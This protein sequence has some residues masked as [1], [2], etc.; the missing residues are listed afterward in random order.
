M[1]RKIMGKLLCIILIAATMTG[2]F[3]N[4]VYAKTDYGKYSNTK[5][6][7]YIMRQEKHKP[8]GGADTAKN[9]LKYN[10][11]YYDGKTE[12]KVMYLA[13]DCGYENGYT[14][15]ILDTLKE[16]NV[17]AMF[18]VTKGFVESNPKLCKRMKKE[19]HMVGN[20]TLNHPSL[21]S[22][23]VKGIK[24]EVKGLAKLFKEKT[25]YELDKYIRPP[26]GEYSNRVLKVLQ[27]MGYTTIFWSIAYYDYD[28]AKQPGKDYVVEHFKK[29]YHKGAITLTHN[30]SK[31][32]TEALGDVLTFL[33][34]K[35]YRFGTLNELNR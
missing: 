31:S 13:F 12:E 34:G 20:H 8:S 27:K 6:S 2:C 35:G 33:E 16:H 7:W 32:N 3:G 24:K 23:S 22:K 4:S 19:G 14:G 5:K 28:P 15:K 11:F 9:L 29:Y 17:K 21:P 10:A 25:G 26:M 1:M 30:I 18:F